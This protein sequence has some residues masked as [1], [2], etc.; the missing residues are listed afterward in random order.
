MEIF[1]RNINDFVPTVYGLGMHVEVRD[2]DDKVLLSR[3][4]Q[5]YEHC[6]DN[7][8]FCASCS[9]CPLAVNIV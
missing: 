9:G 1:D 8:T 7:A 6:Y 5:T 3:V 2:P 4:R